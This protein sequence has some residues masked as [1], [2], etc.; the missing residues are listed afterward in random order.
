MNPKYKRKE[1]KAPAPSAR[2]GTMTQ[3]TEYTGMGLRAIENAVRNGV[4]R[5]SVV[6]S[7]PG[8]KRGRRLVDLRSVDAWI[9]A[10]IGGKVE[11]PYLVRKDRKGGAQ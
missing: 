3:T 6:R 7:F 1:R 9:E 10:G 5:S 11:V 2:W 8:A 4:V